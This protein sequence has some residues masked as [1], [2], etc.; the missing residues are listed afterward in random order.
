MA[1]AKPRYELVDLM[2]GFA[3]LLMIIFHTSFDLNA[4]KFVSIDFNNDLLWWLFPRVIVTLFFLSVGMSLSMAHAKQINWKPYLIRVGKLSI[5]AAAISLMTYYAFPA[6][7]IYFGTLHSI[8]V[9]S[10]LALPFIGKPF[11]ALFCVLLIYSNYF[12]GGVDLTWPTLPHASMDHI[13][14][15]PWFGLILLGLGATHFNVH[16]IAVPAPLK[17]KWLLWMGR[18]S[19]SIY[20][21]H[22]PILYGLTFAFSKV[23]F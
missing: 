12:L 15:Y 13:P 17:P 9:G 2:R 22:Q 21:I 11:V 18:H 19:L 23:F 14:P 5:C 6:N 16:K 1:H 10:L 3:V 8:A 20:L 4:F 7:W